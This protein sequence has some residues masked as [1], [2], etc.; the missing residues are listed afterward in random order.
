MINQFLQ[1]LAQSELKEN[2]KL[3]ALP[4]LSKHLQMSL[5]SLREQLEVARNM[6]VV[7]IKPRSGIRKLPYSFTPSTSTTAAY[8]IT[9]DPDL[10]R[11]Y[12]EMR[13]H[14][15]IAYWYEA[16]KKL[17]EKDLKYLRELILKAKTK[18]K[19]VPFEQPVAEHKALHMTIF[20]N[21]ENVFVTGIL[22]TYWQLYDQLG[23]SLS[24]ELGYHE[25]VWSYHE[26]IVDAI[27]VHDINLSY[28]LL[29][30]HMELLNNKSRPSLIQS[31]E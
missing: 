20:A 28:N 16:V 7:E 2:G 23:L 3:P 1:Y 13:N 26:R 15:E 29:R 12:W 17:Q 5:P 6:G 31:F 22:E 25:K 4:V 10:F 14:L 27:S 30:E 11:Q 8:A 18:L 21:I 24:N 19:A 9:N